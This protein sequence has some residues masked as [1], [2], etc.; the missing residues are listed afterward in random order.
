MVDYVTEFLTE[1]TLAALK[2]VKSDD[3]FERIKEIYLLKQQAMAPYMTESQLMIDAFTNPPVAV[4]KEIEERLKKHYETYGED[5]MFKHFFPKELI[6]TEKLRDDISLADVTNMIML[7]MN[8]LS[9]KYQNLQKKK[10]FDYF[11][12]PTPVIKELDAYLKIVKYGI[13]KF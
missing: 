2:H 1:K 12:N 10:Q 9:T 7:I 5:Y 8:Q 13:Y 11:A 6:Q 3:F 4:K